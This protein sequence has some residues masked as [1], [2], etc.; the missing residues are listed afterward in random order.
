ML[1]I[2]FFLLLLL[3][4]FEAFIEELVVRRELAENYCFYNPNYD[5]VDGFPNWAKETLRAHEKDQREW[6]YT[7][8]ELEYGKTHDTLWNASQFQVFTEKI[9][10]RC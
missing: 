3:Q 5:S 10:C 9:W 2:F 6:L 8:E 7:Q 1:L 4:D